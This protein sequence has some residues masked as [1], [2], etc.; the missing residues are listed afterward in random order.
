MKYTGV[1]LR[2][3][4]EYDDHE[5]G[6]FVEPVKDEAE[7]EKEIESGEGQRWFYSIYLRASDGTVEAV[8]DFE[9][10]V[11]NKAKNRARLLMEI[12][13]RGIK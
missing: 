13:E 8:A 2:V 5:G 12:L 6:T 7:A 1:E 10:E 9:D 11:R 3:V 4:V